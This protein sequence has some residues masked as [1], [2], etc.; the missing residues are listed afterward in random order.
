MCIARNR[1]YYLYP[2]A[3][4]VVSY[5]HQRGPASLSTK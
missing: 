5:H 4:G 2:E 1:R 3:A